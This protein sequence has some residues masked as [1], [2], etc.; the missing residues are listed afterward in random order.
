MSAISC[1]K[2]QRIATH[3][4][5]PPFPGKLGERIYNSISVEAWQEWLA[6]QTLLINEYRLNLLDTNAREF[7]RTE[8]QKY[9]FGEGSDKPEGFI[10]INKEIT[11][12]DGP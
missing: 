1:V 8:M 11:N 4:T 7:L 6:H 3:M 9:F 10:I 12:Y 5:S 2:L